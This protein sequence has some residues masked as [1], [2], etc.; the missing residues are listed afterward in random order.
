MQIKTVIFDLDGTLI[1]SKQGIIDGMCEAFRLSGLVVPENLTIPVGPPLYDT[2]LSVYPD[3]DDKTVELIVQNF[4]KV[5][6]H[7]DIFRSKPFE[8]IVE[9]LKYLNDKNIKVYIATYKPKQFSS[10]VLER[11][12]CMMI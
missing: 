12:F 5:C 6:H 10:K 8:K 1:N 4:R 3:I 11:N 7:F 2:I 9:L